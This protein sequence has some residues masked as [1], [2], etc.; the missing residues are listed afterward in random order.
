MPPLASPR[1][2][3]GLFVRPSDA[4]DVIL[5]FGTYKP[6]QPNGIKYTRVHGLQMVPFKMLT[7]FG[8]LYCLNE[9]LAKSTHDDV[10]H[11]N[12]NLPSAN[13]IWIIIISKQNYYWTNIPI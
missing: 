7:T 2:V 9:P 3:H 8:S 1:A 11:F 10:S 6:Y 5:P 4:P 12:I 13:L